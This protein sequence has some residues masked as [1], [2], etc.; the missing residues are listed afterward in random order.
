MPFVV[1]HGGDVR[2]ACEELNILPLESFDLLLVRPRLNLR[3]DRVGLLDSRL[4]LLLDDSYC[5]DDFALC[6]RQQVGQLPTLEIVVPSG[7][8]G[9]HQ[10]EAEEGHEEDGPESES[11]LQVSGVRCFL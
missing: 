11:F 9:S 7:E 2:F 6:Q 8:D 10:D 5:S 1:G 4:A 3:P